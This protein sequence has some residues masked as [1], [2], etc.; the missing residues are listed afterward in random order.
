MV[1]KNAVQKVVMDVVNVIEPD[2]LKIL[3]E[4]K[5]F[6]K[7]Y[8]S[9][10][11]H[12]L[13]ENWADKICWL[14]AAEGAATAI[15]GAIPGLGTAVQVMVETGAISADMLYMLRCMAGLVRGIGHIYDR[16]MDA[17]FNEQ[18]VRVL[19]IWCGV[20]TPV[21]EASIRITSKVAIAQFKHVSAEIFKRIN[22]KV[23]TT[24][25]TKYGTKRGGIA[26]GR[27]IPF[28]IGIIVGGGF[29]LATMKGFKAAA[30]KYYGT[31]GIVL[32]EK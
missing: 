6:K 16:D 23:G 25:I 24:I 10:S 32:I 17:P 28:G 18:F 12:E 2:R 27:L 26:I 14:Y 22:R 20:L 5:D 3:R 19:G 13:A 11:A 15:P 31:K 1:S 4:I 7:A 8:P 30:I 9:Y 21:K 29:N